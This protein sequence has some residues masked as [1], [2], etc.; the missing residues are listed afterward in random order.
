MKRVALALLLLSAC[1][2]PPA[3]VAAPAPVAP[4]PPPPVLVEAPPPAPEPPPVPEPPPEIVV[5]M[6]AL[7][8]PLVEVRIAPAD[9]APRYPL[10]SPLATTQTNMPIDTVRVAAAIIDRLSGGTGLAAGVSFNETAAQKVDASRAALPG[11]DWRDTRLLQYAPVEY[12]PRLPP[13]GRLVAGQLV[14]A[15]ALGRSATVLFSGEYSIADEPIPVVAIEI[16]PIFALDPAI[17]VFAVEAEALRAA[18]G[19][20]AHYADLL[21]LAR[22]KGV[23]WRA[24]DVP[25][26]EREW[27]LLAFL[28]ERVS[29]S[30]RLRVG[31]TRD[32]NAAELLDA[33][34][35]VL[36]EDGWRVAVLPGRFSAYETDAWLKAEFTAGLEADPAARF[37]RVIGLYDLRLAAAEAAAR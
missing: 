13:T 1:A 25:Q 24:G 3:E 16:A 10:P 35:R 34:T 32:P 20:P 18:A 28:L 5:A 19:S 37:G 6:P 27:V 4:P 33:T 26:G 31:V 15:D 8:P 17:E 2:A 30:S 14:F 9:P 22:E 11:L 21:R 29:P 36:D 7:P 23:P 12:V